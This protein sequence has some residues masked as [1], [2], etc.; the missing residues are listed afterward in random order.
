MLN[1]IFEQKKG[2]KVA[3]F[4]SLVKPVIGGK[5]SFT[6]QILSGSPPLQ[7]NWF[8]DDKKIDNLPAIKILTNGEVSTLIIDE[9]K[10]SHSGNYTCRITNRYGHDSHSAQLLVE[11]NFNLPIN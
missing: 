5:T 11:G 7:I 6:C 3:P 10:S 9:I 1:I 4:S 8:K 2:P